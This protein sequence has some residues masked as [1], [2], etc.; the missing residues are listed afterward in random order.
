VVKINETIKNAVVSH[1]PLLKAIS[2][3]NV[4]RSSVNW[5]K[6][7]YW[8]VPSRTLPISVRSLILVALDGLLYITD[9]SW[10][11]INHPTEVLKMDQKLNVVVLDFDDDKKRISLGLKQLTPHPWDTLSENIKEG[12]VVKGKL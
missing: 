1:K 5:K 12:E 4:Q 3:H 2:K 9:I 10:G 8:K 7:K 6:D 11:R